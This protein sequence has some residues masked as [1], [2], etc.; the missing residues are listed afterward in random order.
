MKKVS[1]VPVLK[2]SNM[3]IMTVSIASFRAGL[4]EF[5]GKIHYGNGEGPVEVIVTKYG[6]P[7][8]KLRTV[9]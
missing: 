2:M 5:M 4:S 1:G 7:F 3:T 8:V 9:K 6:R